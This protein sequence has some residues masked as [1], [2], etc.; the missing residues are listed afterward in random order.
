[1]FHWKSFENIWSFILYPVEAGETELRNTCV[2]PFTIAELGQKCLEAASTLKYEPLNSCI[3]V[4]SVWIMSIFKV[5]EHS[6]GSLWVYVICQIM[7]R[8]RLQFTSWNLASEK[9][10]DERFWSTGKM[11]RFC[12]FHGNMNDWIQ[13]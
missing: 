4:H 6:F 9:Y 7:E 1:M 8:E 5:A 2:V 13:P 12:S 10:T 11:W 3:T